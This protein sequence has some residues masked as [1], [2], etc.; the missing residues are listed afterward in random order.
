MNTHAL[1]LPVHLYRE[2]KYGFI[3]VAS[4]LMLGVIVLL[5]L[6]VF[7]GVLHASASWIAGLFVGGN[8]GGS[9]DSPIKAA[10]GWL[11][12]IVEGG[13]ESV[14]PS[15]VAAAIATIVV[16]IGV[17]FVTLTFITKNM[18]ALVADRIEASLNAVLAKSGTIGIIVGMLVTIAVQSSSIT[19][20]ILIPLV[21]SGLLMVRNAYPI[22]LGANIGTTITALL[23]AMAAGSVD[24][25]TIAFTHTLFNVL[26]ILLVYPWPR[27]RYFPVVLAERLANVAVR[28]KS[29]ALAYTFGAFVVIPF[30]GILVLR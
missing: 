16:A 15:P 1:S 17:I 25:L 18:R 13:I 26:G 7:T 12:K 4:A 5:P 30:L 23:A 28:S 14:I 3:V 8:L 6:E 24:A 27:V 21:A 9:F 11:A 10:V 19:T 20:S 2:H 22:T 29:L